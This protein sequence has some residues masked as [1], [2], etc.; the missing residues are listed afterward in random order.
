VHV[1]IRQLSRTL[2]VP[3]NKVKLELAVVDTGKVG[4]NY[5]SN[6]VILTAWTIRESVRIFSRR[7][8]RSFDRMRY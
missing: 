2:D 7:D 6:G 1:I 4:V 3:P 5:Y 8:P